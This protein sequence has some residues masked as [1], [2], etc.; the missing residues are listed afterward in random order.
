[1][2]RESEL[3]IRVDAN[4]HIG[5]GHV[6]RCLALAQS[7]I[8]KGGVATFLSAELPNG[9]KQN[10]Q[11]NGLQLL[12]LE[13]DCAGVQ[14]L[15]Q[16][17]NILSQQQNK[18]LVIDGY[19][20]NSEYVQSVRKAGNQV[21][22][23]DDG[24]NEN[25]DYDVDII[26]N[27]NL[28]AEYLAYNCGQNT[29]CLLGSKY[30]L[31]RKEFLKRGL[32]KHQISDRASK[33]LVTLGGGD[34][35]NQTL[36]VIRGLKIL[37]QSELDVRV[38]VGASNP[39]FEILEAGCEE[40][41]STIE[42]VQNVE[43]M[44]SLMQWAD[45]A[46]S[47]GGSTCWELGF[48]GVPNLIVVIAE[49]QQPIA[50]ALHKAGISVNLGWFEDVTSEVLA[51]TLMAFLCDKQRREEMCRLGQAKIDGQGVRRVADAIMGAD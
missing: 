39:H 17:T 10:L 31:L 18:W 38:V 6:M 21:L 45:L 11:D 34:P 36:K 48:I 27:Q 3:F 14:D 12:E 20:F 22:V 32:R 24:I 25:F 9:L 43:D 5:T 2:F 28:D 23:I 33:I 50:R 4:I 30:V 8:K 13:G 16:T 7:W 42:V 37:G 47:A 1:M 15:E 40:I 29:R 19:Q 26:L 49:N 35:D 41:D 46:V 44:S 51:E